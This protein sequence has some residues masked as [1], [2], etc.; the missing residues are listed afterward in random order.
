MNGMNGFGGQGGGMN[1]RGGQGQQGGG[2]RGSGG[3]R[4]MQGFGGGQGGFSG[5][6]G[7]MGGGF[8][9]VETELLGETANAPDS[10]PPTVSRQPDGQRLPRAILPQVAAQ[11]AP[12]PPRD[13]Q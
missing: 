13:R 3:K 1:A 2:K 9:N 4:G 6:Q 12:Q 7:G 10:L 8:F 5:G 11:N